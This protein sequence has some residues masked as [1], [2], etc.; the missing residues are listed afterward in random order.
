M[1]LHLESAP[2]H[3]GSRC[4]VSP[5]DAAWTHFCNGLDP[6]RDGG[7]VPSILGFTRALAREH[8]GIRVVTPTPSRL[9]LLDIDPTLTLVGPAPN[10]EPWV[11]QASI[12]HIHGLWQKHGRVGARL[13][14]KHRVPYLVAA[15]GMADPWA[16]R[17]KAWKK[18]IYARLIED[19]NLQHAACL[20]ALARPEVQSLRA[21]A[22]RT[23]I[24]LSPNG[25][26]LQ[27]FDNLPPRDALVDRYPNLRDRFLLL[28]FS[29][30]HPKKGLDLL[31]PAFAAIA[32]EHPHVH[33]LLAGKDDGALTPFLAHIRY[34]RLDGRVTVLGHLAGAAAREAWGAADAFVLPSYSEG[35]SM[36]VL[37]ALA[38]R[39]PALVTHACNFPDL[40]T[41]RAAITVDSSLPGVEQGLRDLLR[42][43]DP[44]RRAMAARGRELVETHYTWAAQAR[45]L[46]A[47]Y[48]WLTHGGAMPECIVTPS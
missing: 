32:R 41:E 42:M 18:Q 23:P 35:F 8:D 15:H 44:D 20:H 31:A 26:D 5:S 16:L 11:R 46:A 1:S 6:V 19:R 22:P 3:G 48:R 39:V 10:L 27:P 25:V 36:S 40:E 33:L 29:R 43:S 37:E 4:D 45:K 2:H 47:V 17:Q 14:R 24:A 9:D 34:A 21:L 13:A 38:A 28:F 12:V 7:M 30:V